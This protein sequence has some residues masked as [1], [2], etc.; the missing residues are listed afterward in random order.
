MVDVDPVGFLCMVADSATTGSR[1]SIKS[2]QQIYFERIVTMNFSVSRL[3]GFGILLF[4]ERRRVDP[5]NQFYSK[6]ES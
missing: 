5:K 2:S 3:I 6:S 4:K 1:S